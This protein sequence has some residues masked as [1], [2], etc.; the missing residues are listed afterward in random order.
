M[1][2]TIINNNSKDNKHKNKNQQRN[3]IRK[4]STEKQKQTTIKKNH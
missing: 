3:K 4:I 2:K 1:H